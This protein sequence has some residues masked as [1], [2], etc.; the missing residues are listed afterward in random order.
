MT[1]IFDVMAKAFKK[2]TPKISEPQTPSVPRSQ[3][4]DE[5]LAAFDAANDFS[6]GDPNY[7]FDENAVPYQDPG[8]SRKQER[9]TAKAFRTERRF[10]R[11]LA[12]TSV[13]GEGNPEDVYASMF[14]PYSKE[15]D[16][17][18]RKL[19]ITPEGVNNP[20]L[21]GLPWAQ[22]LMPGNEREL[23]GI[24]DALG[25][26]SPYF[27]PEYIAEME[28]QSWAN[29]KITPKAVVPEGFN[30]NDYGETSNE[31]GYFD[32]KGNWIKQGSKNDA[33][34][35]QTKN[36]YIEDPNRPGVMLN[37]QDP[38]VVKYL[39]KIQK[40]KGAPSNA[41]VDFSNAD[42]YRV[43]ERNFRPAFTRSNTAAQKPNTVFS[44][45]GV[46]YTQEQIN[47]MPENDPIRKAIETRIPNN[48]PTTT[49]QKM[50]DIAYNYQ[51]RD[52]T[53]DELNDPNN[54]YVAKMFNRDLNG[55]AII[56]KPQNVY[57]TAT[58]WRKKV[59]KMGK[60]EKIINPTTIRTSYK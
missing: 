46:N 57:Q 44:L 54:A 34:A 56:H 17:N 23:A 43:P 4:T 60:K 20:D 5:E 32:V 39:A 10:N 26:A 59:A 18:N 1:Q 3:M 45:D 35:F 36:Q 2:K 50:S 16:V 29:R 30:P 37:S 38:A 53:W 11:E 15:Q 55:G 24:S 22:D 49:S 47:A 7:V 12:N 41:N 21:S 8:L 28:R 14:M 40:E 51:G 13:N 52:Y 33:Y 42:V 48:T 6:Q 27:T 25:G 31:T 9:Q 58:A 19:N